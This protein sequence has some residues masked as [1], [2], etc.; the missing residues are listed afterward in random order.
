MAEPSAEE[1]VETK[2]AV[3]ANKKQNLDTTLKKIDGLA[4]LQSEG[5]ISSEEFEEIKAEILDKKD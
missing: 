1:I 3:K 2:G 5:L 4:K